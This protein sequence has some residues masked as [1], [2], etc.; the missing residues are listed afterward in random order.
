[1][2]DIMH[3]DLLVAVVDGDHPGA[4]DAADM[5]AGNS[6]VYCIH[7]D[8]GSKLRLF[9]RRSDRLHRLVNVDDN[10]P[11]QPFAGRLPHTQYMDAVL[12]VDRSDHGT[13]L[14]RSDI[15]SCYDLFLFIHIAVRLWLTCSGFCSS[16]LP[17]LSGYNLV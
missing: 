1:T 6:H 8:S 9:H 16:I 5:V 15:E 11:V 13:D 14:G 3:G 12:F 10:P 2:L 17:A 4:P 7:L